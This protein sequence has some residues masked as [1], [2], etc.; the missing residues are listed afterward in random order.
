MIFTIIPLTLSCLLMGAHFLRSGNPIITLFC[1]LAPFLLLIKKQWVLIFLQ[2]FTYFGG[3]IWINTGI[4]LMRK[5]ISLGASWSKPLIIV[6]SVALFTIFSGL[7]L[8]VKY[9]KE[10]YP[11]K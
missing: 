10:R 8:N 2:C 4:N 6:G 11:K 7:L 9:L 1:L 3:I 5:R